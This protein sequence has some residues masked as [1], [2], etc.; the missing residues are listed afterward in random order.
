MVRNR[1]RYRE[2]QTE[3]NV[4]Y[5]PKNIDVLVSAKADSIAYDQII[6]H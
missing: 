6:L 3:E 2:R 4:V 5:I 1:I